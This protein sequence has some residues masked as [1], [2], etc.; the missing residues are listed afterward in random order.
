MLAEEA[1]LP[2]KPPVW[3]VAGPLLGYWSRLWT[4]ELSAEQLAC[5]LFISDKTGEEDEDTSSVS[6]SS[7]DPCGGKGGLALMTVSEDH[8]YCEKLRHCLK[9]KALLV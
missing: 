4:P 2:P 6:S 7:F 8:N 1:A 5:F 9:K 3:T